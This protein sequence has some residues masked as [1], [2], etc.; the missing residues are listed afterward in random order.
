MSSIILE[1]IKCPLL[2]IYPLISRQP[3]VPQFARRLPPGPRRPILA[4]CTT[5]TLHINQIVGWKTWFS[6]VLNSLKKK[7]KQSEG[8]QAED[9][10]PLGGSCFIYKSRTSKAGFVLFMEVSGSLSLHVV[11]FLSPH[12]NLQLL[13][14]KA[15]FPS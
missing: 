14:K 5:T 12:V 1:F 11:H 8:S 13:Q 15:S 3:H 10:D 7:H 2:I 6:N 9:G 4:F